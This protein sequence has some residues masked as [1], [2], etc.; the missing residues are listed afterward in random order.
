MLNSK[1]SHIRLKWKSFLQAELKFWLLITLQAFVSTT[2]IDERVAGGSAQK[3]KH[4][5]KYK[6]SE[7]I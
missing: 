3:S 2:K 1:L 5:E 6:P 7:I 4:W